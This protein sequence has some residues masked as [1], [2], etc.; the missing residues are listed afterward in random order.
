MYD[1]C[2][3]GYTEAQG[4]W[5]QIQNTNWT[6]LQMQHLTQVIFT[7][8]PFSSTTWMNFRRITSLNSTGEH[9]TSRQYQEISKQVSP[10]SSLSLQTVFFLFVHFLFS[11][12]FPFLLLL[13]LSPPP[14]PLAS[15]FSYSASQSCFPNEQEWARL[16]DGNSGPECRITFASWQLLFC[17]PILLRG[18]IIRDGSPSI[19]F[20]IFPEGTLVI[21]SV[22]ASQI[23]CSLESRLIH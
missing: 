2:L 6:I 9:F 22:F 1:D 21:F 14:P 12:S 20:S 7:P 4:N 8:L 15:S 3:S 10:S 23:M 5:F 17:Q 19:L 16:T 11:S 13:L 18:G